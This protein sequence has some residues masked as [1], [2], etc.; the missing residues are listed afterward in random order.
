MRIRWQQFVTLTLA[1]SWDLS[2]EF[3]NHQAHCVNLFFKAVRA[4]VGKWFPYVWIRELGE[5][6]GRLHIHILWNAG[7]IPQDWLS[8]TAVSCGL[9]EVLD[10]RSAISK[11]YRNTTL[12]ENYLSKAKVAHYVSKTESAF[13]SGTRIAQTSGVPRYESEPGYVYQELAP[14]FTPIEP[15]FLLHLS[16]T[17]KVDNHWRSWVPEHMWA[18]PYCDEV[19]TGQEAVK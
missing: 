12:V 1:G 5:E 9:G 6:K 16:I 14:D 3:L 8:A 15:V 11:G 18:E 7:Y 17:A 2:A 10:V 4:R 13:P 19:I